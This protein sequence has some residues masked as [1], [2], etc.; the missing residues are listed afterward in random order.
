M[1]CTRRQHHRSLDLLKHLLLLALLAGF[2]PAAHAQ[3]DAA[4]D[5]QVV[6]DHWYILEMAGSTAG[7]SNDIVSKRGNEIRTVNS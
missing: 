1:R 2:F 4:D 5:W 6:D 7:W 3:D